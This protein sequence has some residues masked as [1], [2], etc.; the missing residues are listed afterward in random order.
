MMVKINENS[1]LH[2]NY[3]DTLLVVRVE[4]IKRNYAKIDMMVTAR[5]D[6]TDNY[7]VHETERQLGRNMELSTRTTS[8]SKKHIKELLEKANKYYYRVKFIHTVKHSLH[9]TRNVKIHVIDLL[10]IGDHGRV[11]KV[12]TN[13]HVLEESMDKELK[14]L[15]PDIA[16][17]RHTSIIADK[18]GFTCKNCGSTEPIKKTYKTFVV[19]TGKRTYNSVYGWDQ[20]IGVRKCWNDYSP[21]IEIARWDED[22]NGKAVY[23]WLMRNGKIVESL[24]VTRRKPVTKNNDGTKYLVNVESNCE[25]NITE[26]SNKTSR[27]IKG[28]MY[29]ELTINE[30]AHLREYGYG[31]KFHDEL[32][33]GYEHAYHYYKRNPEVL[34]QVKAVPEEEMVAPKWTSWKRV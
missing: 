17:C 14:E 4:K 33:R 30:L 16:P 26:Y 11:K 7:L 2:L 20:W 22:E 9:P 19:K 6:M 13:H 8:G 21:I 12:T 28:L 29:T 24:A 25:G 27:K 5:N 31:V 10:P 15:I 32:D 18:I 23:T 1:L 34:E 3:T